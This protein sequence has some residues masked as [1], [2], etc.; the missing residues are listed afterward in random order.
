[1]KEKLFIGV[2]WLGA[3]K[4]IINFLALISTIILARLLTPEDFGLVAIVLALLAIIEAV[5]DLSLASALIHIKEPSEEHFHTAWSLNLTRGVFLA[6]IF[7][8]S[9]EFIA[10]YYHDVRLTNIMWIIS[11]SILISGFTN[12]KMV[13]LTKKLI[14]WQEFVVTVSQKLMSVI[15]SVVFAFLFRSYWALIAGVITSQ[16][17]GVLVSYLIIS[18]KPKFTYLHLRDIWSFSI[19]LTLGKIVNTLNWK[20][21]QLLIGSQLGSKSLGFYTVGDNLAGLPTREAIQPLENTLFPGFS[22]IA[23]DKERLRNAYVKSQ[24]LITAIALPL[25]IGFAAISYPLVLLLMGAKW[26]PSVQV[27]QVISCIYVLQTIGSQVHP[28]AMAVGKTKTL[29]YRDM[30]NF[31]IRLPIIIGGLF[32]FGLMGVIFGRAI[33]G[34]IS[35]LINMHL[36]SKMLGISIWEQVNSNARAIASVLGMAYFLLVIQTNASFESSSTFEL[37]LQ[38]IGMVLSAFLVYAGLNLLLWLLMNKPSGPESELLK[39]LT[40]VLKKFKRFE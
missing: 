3:A 32:Y 21:D 22:H 23:E 39:V 40:T 10:N 15:V 35:L 11:G 6:F 17:V 19:W 28:I 7:W 29:F 20:F 31:I 14:F 5:T 36:I 37:A 8:L 26:L 9:S 33:S 1:M 34:S 4:L 24:T 30:L 12:P 27:I 13:V 25:G 2:F 18:Y 38:V 16:L